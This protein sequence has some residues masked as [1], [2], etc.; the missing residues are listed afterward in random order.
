MVSES[1]QNLFESVVDGWTDDD[2]A[3][4]CT[5]LKTLTGFNALA[6]WDYFDDDGFGGNSEIVFVKDN[7]YYRISP[8][9]WSWL[10]GDDGSD[11]LKETLTDS[12]NWIGQPA[13]DL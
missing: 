6:V 8:S 11:L 5:E 12:I 10:T 7:E 1:V 4:I 3:G 13:P 9:A 2:V